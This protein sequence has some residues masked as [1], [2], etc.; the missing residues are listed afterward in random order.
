MPAGEGERW[1]HRTAAI[2]ALLASVSCAPEP[3]P[4]SD[5]VVLRAGSASATAR[6]TSTGL[7]GANVN[8]ELFGTEL[9]GHFNREPVSLTIDEDASTVKGLLGPEPV[10]LRVRTDD[11]GL[12]INGLFAGSIADY[13][14][15]SQGLAGQIGR[16]SYS[17]RTSA[18]VF[19]GERRCAYQDR[20][21]RV[22]VQTPPGMTDLPPPRYA[23]LMSLML[24]Q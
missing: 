10:N 4:A 14:I 15:D 23:A 9:R 17:L 2:L 24:V 7:H 21:E 11:R 3:A 16:C 20:N 1:L 22:E 19:R 5:D 18:G 8:V 12:H 13:G 6:M